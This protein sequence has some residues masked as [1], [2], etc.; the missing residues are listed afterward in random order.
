MI[1]LKKYF[2]ILMLFTLV[3][4]VYSQES[5]TSDDTANL[6]NEALKLYGQKNYSEA[7]KIARQIVQIKEKKFGADDIEIAKAL[8][9]VA[10][11]EIASGNEKDG[12]LTARRAIAIFETKQDLTSDDALAFARTFEAVGFIKFRSK[13]PE[14]AL[15]EYARALAIKEKYIGQQSL[16]AS[17]TLWQMGNIYLMTGKYQDS[18]EAYER[19]VKIRSVYVEQIGY[20]E[21]YSAI[22][23]Y[24][25]A[26]GKSY[27]SLEADTLIE[28]TRSKMRKS[29]KQETV[30]GGVVNGKALKLAKPRYPEL[31]RKARASGSIKVKVTIDETGKIIFACAKSGH[32]LLFA[33]SEQAAL[34]SKFAPTTLNGRPVKVSGFI[35]YNFVP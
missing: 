26:A 31:A 28:E 20:D 30:D 8:S 1:M 14:D 19:V 24:D 18:F 13:K 12:E 21:I 33:T 15:P 34:N 10:T 17:K 2:L 23:R 11:I 6:R 32:P 35:V 3:Q 9:D 27:N 7:L 16:E 25:C 5:S 4:A 29:R 22:E